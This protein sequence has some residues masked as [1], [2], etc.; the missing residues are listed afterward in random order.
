ML[1]DRATNVRTAPTVS[2]VD[3]CWISLKLRRSPPIFVNLFQSWNLPKEEFV[4]A[5]CRR[6]AKPAA[7][8]ACSQDLVMTASPKPPLFSRRAVAGFLAAFPFLFALGLSRRSGPE[9]GFVEID[10][11]ILKRSDL[12]RK[13]GR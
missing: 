9:D 8:I 12:R 10:G 1:L 4:E 3:F 2:D 11:W 6:N 13:S 7:T 5:A